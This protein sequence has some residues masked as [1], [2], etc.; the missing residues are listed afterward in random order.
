MTAVLLS[1]HVLGAVVLIGPVTAA[2]SLFPRY[3]RQALDSPEHRPG[4][5]AVLRVLHRISTGYAV[6][7]LGVPAFGIATAS[8][9]GVLTDAWVLA[10]M[11]LTACAAAVLAVRV[12]PGQRELLASFEKGAL[13][14]PLADGAARLAARL[15]GGT[16]I[17]ALLWAVVVVL[18]VVRPGSTTGV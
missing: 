9:L 6:V 11:A 4:S 3:A 7:G 13:S 15:S 18:M 5:V 2:A 17:F 12:V 14:P 16:G 1:I 8:S 10:S